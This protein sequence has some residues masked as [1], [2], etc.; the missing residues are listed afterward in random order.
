MS[1]TAKANHVYNH[2]SIVNKLMVHTVRVRGVGEGK[3]SIRI[4]DFKQVFHF[5][6]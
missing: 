2:M 6:P 3:Q 5:L 4:L 1:Q